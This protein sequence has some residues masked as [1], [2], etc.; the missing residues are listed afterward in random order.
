MI[1]R[2][3]LNLFCMMALLVA[4]HVA[5]LAQTTNKIAPK[6]EITLAELGPNDEVAIIIEFLNKVDTELFGNPQL[7]VRR[8]ALIEDLQTTADISQASVAALL[9]GSGARNIRQLWI[10][11]SLAATVPAFLVDALAL[12]PEVARIKLDTLIPLADATAKEPPLVPWNLIAI[13]APDLSWQ[14]WI[15][16]SIWLT[17]LWR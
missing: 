16:G 17:L 7:D 11:N 1:K 9:A 8:T 2:V 4:V 6:L 13:E 10:V 15:P 3:T 14:R 12:W 5:A